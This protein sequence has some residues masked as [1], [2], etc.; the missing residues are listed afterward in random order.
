MRI[1]HTVEA[2]PPAI[3]GMAE[4]ARQLSKRLAERGH[5]V[6]VATSF[7]PGRNG[8]DCSGV[9]VEQFKVRGNAVVGI[10]G[11]AAAYEKFLLDAD[12]DVVVNFAAQQWATDL[13]LPLLPRVRGKKIMVPTG[14]PA[15]GK[16]EYSGYFEQMKGWLRAYDALV[17]LSEGFRDYHFASSLGLSN[18]HVIPNG[19]DEREFSSLAA[20]DLRERLG[21]SEKHSL[22]LLVGSHTGL[23]GHKEAM[24]LF[25]RAKIRGATLLIVGN[26]TGEG[27]GERCARRAARFRRSPER[28][29]DGKR[30]ILADLPRSQVLQ[31]Y[32]ASDVFLFP[33]N[34]ECSPL[35]I[36]EAMAAGVPFLSTRVGNVEELAALGGG[37]VM[38]G[39]EDGPE[40]YADV[41]AGARALKALVADR[42]KREGMGQKGR[43]VWKERF[44]WDKI[45]GEYET[46]YLTV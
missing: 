34:L 23:K 8:K 9:C 28:M 41:D 13:A 10:E 29:L 5:D 15:L 39:R 38:P 4:V 25:S 42:A 17:F 20:G 18:M 6:T 16:P 24:Q 7:H 30:M 36:F 43:E 3:G 44:T 27:C 21:I 12:F 37:L 22:I 32:A 46:L 19:A 33:S 2:Y 31:A 40:T 35:V 26:D 1:L 14:F 11:D 45:T